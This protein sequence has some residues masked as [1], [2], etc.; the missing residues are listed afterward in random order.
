MAMYH[1]NKYLFLQ[2]HT[3]SISLFKEDGIAPKLIPEGGELVETPFSE[4]PQSQF[5]LAHCPWHYRS[6]QVIREYIL[7]KIKQWWLFDGS[8]IHKSERITFL[9]R[10]LFF[11]RRLQVPRVHLF[12]KSFKFTFIV[13]KVTSRSKWVS[14]G[15]LSGETLDLCFYSPAAAVLAGYWLLLFLCG[16]DLPAPEA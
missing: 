2:L 6:R 10:L 7:T 14:T 5:G 13:L 4:G 9:F 8:V 3:N 11:F 15:T 12:L 1:S 16:T